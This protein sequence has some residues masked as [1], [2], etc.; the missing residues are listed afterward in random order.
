MLNDPQVKHR[1]HFRLLQHKVI[2][3]HHYHT[4]A[5]KLSKTPAHLWKASPCL[6]QDNDFVYEE[7][8]GYTDEEVAQ[9][10]LDGVITTEHDIPDILK[11][12]K[13]K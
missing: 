7:L 5:Y 13:P 6:G 8:L 10:L 12:R 4:P 1:E 11:P 2:G 3:W 9:L